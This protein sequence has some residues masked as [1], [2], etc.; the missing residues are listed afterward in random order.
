MALIDQ[1]EKE[2]ISE[3][4]KRLWDKQVADHGQMTNMKRTMAHSAT[5]LGAYMTWYPLKDRV[6]EVLGERPTIIFVHAVSSDTDCLICSTFFRRI[7]KD[8]GEDPDDL[9]LNDLEQKLVE[10]ARAIATDSNNVP[11]ELI[12]YFKDAYGQTLVVDLI[13]LAGI[14]V[15]TNIFNNALQIPLDE[16]LNNYRKTT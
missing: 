1:A 2:Q 14:M 12:R 15:A 11:N 10:L 4:A 6:A 8:W 3:D 13:G 16:Y 5:T 7:L 9:Q